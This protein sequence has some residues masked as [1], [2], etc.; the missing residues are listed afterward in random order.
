MKPPPRTRQP[1]HHAPA[2][3]PGTQTLP[4]EEAG[5]SVAGEEDPGSADEE[6]LPGPEREP[7]PPSFGQPVRRRTKLP[8]AD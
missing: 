7:L 5:F 3:Q 2:T 1:I 4:A 8:M 6:L